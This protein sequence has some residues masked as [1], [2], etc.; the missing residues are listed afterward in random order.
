MKSC[1]RLGFFSFFRAEASTCLTSTVTYCTT[2]AGEEWLQQF[3]ISSNPEISPAQRRDNW[4]VHDCAHIKGSV[5]TQRNSIYS[6]G[7]TFTLVIAERDEA[8]C[9]WAATQAR[10]FFMFF[11]LGAPQVCLKCLQRQWKWK[12]FTSAINRYFRYL[13]LQ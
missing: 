2:A 10:F 6:T 4:A 12:H 7:T 8:S 3:C 13:P 11:I 1:L 5:W 9:V